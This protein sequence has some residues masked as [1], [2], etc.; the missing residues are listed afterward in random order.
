[1]GHCWN[2]SYRREKQKYSENKA[3][4]C[5]TLSTTQPTRIHLRLNP[6]TRG[7]VSDLVTS[8]FQS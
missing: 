1:M 3:C 8:E 6:V 5:A 2:D 7:N 4:L